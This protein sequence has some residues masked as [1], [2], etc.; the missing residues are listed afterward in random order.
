MLHGP[1]R[2]HAQAG[3]A[4]SCRPVTAPWGPKTRWQ[5][6]HGL[7]RARCVWQGPS[8][9]LGAP[10]LV[11]SLHTRT[12]ALGRHAQAA[13]CRPL[14]AGQP[15]AAGSAPQ[16][17]KHRTALGCRQMER[18]MA[19]G[20]WQT[21][22]SALAPRA[23]L[24][25]PAHSACVAQRFGAHGAGPPDR[26]RLQAAPMSPGCSAKLPGPASPAVN[27][28]CAGGR[29]RRVLRLLLRQALQASRMLLPDPMSKAT[30]VRGTGCTRSA[31]PGLLAQA[32]WPGLEASVGQPAPW[33]VGS[34]SSSGRTHSC[35]HP[36]CHR[37]HG[38]RRPAR[39]AQGATWQ[40][41][42]AAW[43]TLGVRGERWVNSWL[44]SSRAGVHFLRAWRLEAMPAQVLRVQG[45]GFC[46]PPALLRCQQ[47]PEQPLRSMLL[48]RASSMAPQA[49]QALLL[50][51]QT[52][53]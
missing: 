39:A 47:C 26:G 27:Q 35:A 40:A 4:P 19:R 25:L 10:C 51:L 32:T 3:P 36:V 7:P 49:C 28:R 11:S 31:P 21:G 44:P 30:P 53:S 33:R 12:A 17:V 18:R 5:A 15:H 14:L 45:V 46:V 41:C 50:L 1:C 34:G 2:R 29:Q 42:S 23:A 43:G 52:C 48:P 6:T 24:L 20:C 16:Q 9:R 38:L 22:S 37:Q 13:L 8:P